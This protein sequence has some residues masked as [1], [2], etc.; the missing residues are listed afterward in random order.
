MNP[1][2]VTGPAGGGWG[3]IK[4]CI[5]SAGISEKEGVGTEWPIKIEGRDDGVIH[6]I[7]VIKRH[8]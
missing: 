6:L 5:D 8:N 2:C 7:R 4:M 3:G 1:Y